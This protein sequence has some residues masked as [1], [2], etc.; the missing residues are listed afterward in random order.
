MER[1]VRACPTDLSTAYVTGQHI[2]RD[3]PSTWHS[4]SIVSRSVCRWSVS[5]ELCERCCGQCD[6]GDVETSGFRLEER[7]VS[8]STVQEV[9]FFAGCH[10]IVLV[11]LTSCGP[12]RLDVSID[13]VGPSIRA[14]LDC[15]V[16]WSYRIWKVELL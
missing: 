9:V 15:S 7:C 5:I 2:K 13:C 10:H 12:G 1:G 8:S 3:R 16:R 14:A 4:Q 6:G 11:C